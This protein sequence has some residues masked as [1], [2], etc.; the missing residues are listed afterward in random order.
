[1]ADS[2]TPERG[3][4][5]TYN[6]PP[7]R[8]R[9][10]ESDFNLSRHLIPFLQDTPFYA[11]LSRHIAKRFTCDVPTAGVVYDPRNDDVVLYCNPDF[12]QGCTYTLPDGSK[13]ALPALS[14]SEI[15]GTLKHEFSHVVFG[16][17]YAR[18]M[19]PAG[20]W[21]QA[22]DLA[23]NSLIVSAA[24]AAVNQDDADVRP[25][26]RGTLVPG[27]RLWID[28]AA[29][30]RMKPTDKEA[31]D[32]KAD[33][34]EKLPLLKASEWYFNAL[35]EEFGPPPEGEG[36]GP[37]AFDDHGGWGNIPDDMREYVEGKVKSIVE[38]AVKFADS[39]ADGWGDIPAELREE[40]RRSVSKLIDWRSVQRQFI[41]SLARGKRSTSIKQ[42]NR[43][44][45]YIH[46]GVKRG[47]EAKLAV[48]IDQS[49][50]VHDEML[51]LFFGELSNLTKKVSIDIIHFDCECNESDVFPWRKGTSLPTRRTRTGGTDFN[52]PTNFVNDP[53]NRGRWDGLLIMTD[54]QAAQPGPSRTK[55]GWVLGK[56]CKLDFPSTEIQIF[57][58]KDRQMTGAWR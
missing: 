20:Y 48:A 24:K 52:A 30:A 49:G 47:Y 55:R 46:P 37:G 17:L 38:K 43:R 34:I 21:A 27:E 16:H 42:I 28:P 18:I 9:Q 39:H 53:K 54:G 51:E 57:P 56:G 45:P 33:F 1:M 32:R 15:R 50:S 31:F 22:T 11:E 7:E 4:P 58:S 29:Y 36:P 35:Y 13:Q 23:I 12:F 10:V 3:V 6:V 40:I 14:N 5:P 44:Y 2:G 8:W 25:L 19:A 41:G 26:P